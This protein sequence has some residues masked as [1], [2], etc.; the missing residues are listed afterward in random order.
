MENRK[1]I[2]FLEVRWG[3]KKRR[4]RTKPGNVFL[5][6]PNSSKASQTGAFSVSRSSITTEYQGLW[7]L[8]LPPDQTDPFK[9]TGSFILLLVEV[10]WRRR[11]KLIGSTLRG[12]RPKKCTR[13]LQRLNQ[14]WQLVPPVSLYITVLSN[15]FSSKISSLL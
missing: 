10:T 4:R 1:Y 13:M 5:S 7:P 2:L 3:E 12:Y 6:L 15:H 9:I 14:V 11:K 8:V